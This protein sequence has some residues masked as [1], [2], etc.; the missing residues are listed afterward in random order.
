MSSG[1]ACRRQKER[2]RQPDGEPRGVRVG[3][4]DERA[5]EAEEEL[6][7]SV[8]RA[9]EIR[10]DHGARAAEQLDLAEA[11]ERVVDVVLVRDEGAVEAKGEEAHDERDKQLLDTAVL[12]EDLRAD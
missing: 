9:T 6:N 10:R 3:A 8:G 11:C 5:E 1:W 2:E 7:L 12:K 4:Q